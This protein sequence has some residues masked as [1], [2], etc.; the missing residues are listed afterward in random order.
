MHILL[1]RRERRHTG[2]QKDSHQTGQ[3]LAYIRMQCEVSA[4][5]VLPLLGT[6]T[7]LWQ[8]NLKD[9]RNLYVHQG[10]VTLQARFAGK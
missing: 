5:A 3:M 8:W 9:L 7:S 10:T 6:L 2:H 4:L 1:K